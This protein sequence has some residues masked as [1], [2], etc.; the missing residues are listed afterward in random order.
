[1]PNSGNFTIFGSSVSGSAAD[2]NSEYLNAN[3]LNTTEPPNSNTG[4]T[5]TA[6]TNPAGFSFANDDMPRY[7][8]KTVW[9]KDLVLLED[10]TR[11]INNRP[12]YQFI[13]SEPQPHIQGYAWGNIRLKN[14]NFGKTVSVI[15]IGDGIAVSGVIRNLGWIIN[16]TTD[17]TGTAAKWTDGVDLSA[18]VSFGN[19]ALDVNVSGNNKYNVQIHSSTLLTRNIHEYR[20]IANQYRTL[21]VPGVVA[22]FENTTAD[23]DQFPGNTYVTMFRESTTV[24][25]DIA[26][27]SISG[28]MGGRSSIAKTLI[29]SYQFNTV[30]TS[31]INSIGI[32]ASGTNLMTVTTGQGGSFPIGSGIAAISG[33]SHYIGTV[34]NQSTDTLTVSPTLPFGLSGLVY[35]GWQGGPTFAISASLYTLASTIDPKLSNTIIDPRGFGELQNGTLFYSDPE[36][37]YRFWGGNLNVNA[38]EGYQGVGFISNTL[39]F[40]Q[41]DGYFCAAEV[42]I[43]AAGIVHG[44]FSINGVP[45]WGLNE[46]VSAIL[47]KTVFTNAGPG[48]NS[49]SFSPGQSLTQ[50]NFFRIN[51]YN[52]MDPTGMTNTLLGSFDTTISPL[53]RFGDAANASL[54][55]L[56]NWQRV[57]ADQC[58][59]S[60]QWARGATSGAAGGV[61]FLGTSTNSILNFQYFGTDFEILG[62][63]GSSAILTIDGASTTVVVGARIPV[64]GGATFHTVRYTHQNG[65]SFIQGFDFLKPVVGEIKNN[66]NYT[67]REE[68][69]EMPRVFNQSDTPRNPKDFDVWAADKFGKVVMIYLFGK[70]N[71]IVLG[72]QLDDPN[73][74]AM[75]RLHGTT[76]NTDAASLTSAETFNFFSWSITQAASSTAINRSQVGD[77]SFN[78]SIYF[79]DGVNAAG[80][81]TGF[82]EQ[83]NKFS[84]TVGATRATPKVSGGVAVLNFLLVAGKGITALGSTS[85][86]VIDTFNG[87]SWTSTVATASA[88]VTAASGFVQGGVVRWVGGWNVTGGSASNVH[89]TFNG[90]SSATS[91]VFPES[92]VAVIGGSYAGA[93]VAGGLASGTNRSY[94]WSGSWSANIPLAATVSSADMHDGNRGPMT[95]NYFNA[96]VYINGGLSAANT[97]TN[98][99]QVYNGSSWAVDTASNQSIGG[100]GGGTT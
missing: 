46:G 7:G 21:S 90:S 54:M 45:A 96:K 74:Q 49:F 16:P 39:G 37:K 48:W 61:Q 87:T 64:A 34:T 10:R 2:S 22:Y 81:L 58:Y 78:A 82:T 5:S 23:I 98:A 29:N 20:L 51:L 36:G 18:T 77:A 72:T 92:D 76:N 26:L 40:F 3:F 50:A 65:N 12:T 6:L 70:W 47:R 97:A 38:I 60:G 53:H 99:S 32:G 31:Y 35:R 86:G 69:N 43:A 11:W 84:F 17:A 67:P 93:G 19:A 42:E 55:P 89:D 56:G 27:P 30:P 1:M 25:E 63:A 73:D 24:G 71:Q 91:T 13:W 4:F 80:S 28:N 85:S 9:I 14:T 79:V 8:T 88:P 95:G 57:Y 15:D 66:Q 83:F 62:T 59:F 68:F 52:Q 75:Y 41:V 94:A 100:C 44:T 33:T